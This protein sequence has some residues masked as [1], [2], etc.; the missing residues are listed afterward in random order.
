MAS[1][2]IFVNLVLKDVTL[3]SGETY[4]VGNYAIVNQSSDYSA[5][6]NY[7]VT[8]NSAIHT[9][10]RRQVTI[11]AWS[12]SKFFGDSDPEFRFGVEL[13]QFA[14]LYKSAN[15]IVADVFSAY[16]PVTDTTAD[17][18]AL[19]YAG[20]SI[21]RESAEG[22]GQ[23]D[24][25]S[26]ASLFDID[27]NYSI[28]VQTTKYKFTIEKRKVTLDVSG[29]SSVFPFGTTVESEISKIAPT[30]KIAAEDMV[31]ASQIEALFA[32]GA[33]LSLGAK[34][35]ELTEEEDYSA[36][37]K[38]AIVLGGTLDDGNVVIELDASGA[39]YI[40]YVTKQN[41][42]VVKVKDGV[43]FEFVYGFVWGENTLVFDSE[44]FELQGTPSGE[45]T[46]VKW[47]VD[48]AN[49]TILDAGKR[50]LSISGAKLY[51]GETA[52][53][54]AVFVEPVTVTINPATIVV[55]P[56]AQNLSK[57]YGEEDGVYGIGF[58]VASV[59]GQAIAKDGSYANVAYND[60]LAQINGV[61]VRAIFDK[62]GNRL[63]FAS[64]YDG[65]TDASGTVYGTDGRYY[66]F[67][68][69]TPFST[70]NSNFKVEAAVDSTQN[71]QSSKRA[72]T[73]QPSISSVLAKHTTERPTCS[74]TART[75]TICP[76]I[77]CLQPMT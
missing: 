20:G 64:R 28:I 7:D 18:Y 62:N 39:E 4:R 21:S 48:V 75:F 74:T 52:L 5:A 38:Y 46:S 31:V 22:V 32:N 56:T 12:A 30:Y 59:G 23:Y 69:G 9:V 15:E 49:G 11:D 43:N 77:L 58:D 3:A 61:F 2:N 36:V 51:N 45:Y 8:F 24:F 70:Q 67:A 10:T 68:V 72:S 53:E 37:Y 17:G 54:D 34:I 40:V 29:Q 47:S 33:K 27:S 44:K 42:I 50:I 26:D 16:K 71:L 14:G 73:F 66:G 25:A 35:A 41:A 65:A 60:I 6:T 55:K 13:A 63:S 76:R 19:F 57:V 1:E